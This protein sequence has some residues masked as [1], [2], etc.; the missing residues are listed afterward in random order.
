MKSKIDA[1]GTCLQGYV[2]V[3]YNRLV[4]VFGEP[5]RRNGCEKTTVEWDFEHEGIRFTIYDYKW[6]S[7]Q[8]DT[9][10]SFHV[11]GDAPEALTLVQKL[12]G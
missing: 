1:S 7:C 12:I 3:S 8:N 11:G 9:K 5:H 2:T 4:E 10:E 6:R